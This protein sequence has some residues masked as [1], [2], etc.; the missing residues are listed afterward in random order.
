MQ[1]A[2]TVRVDRIEP[3]AEA[4]GEQMVIAVPAGAARLAP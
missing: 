2:W 1:H 4:L 3:R